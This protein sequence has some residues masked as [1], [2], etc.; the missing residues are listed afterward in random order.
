MR[1]PL[2]GIRV[3]DLTIWQQGTYAS[4]L[5]ADLGAD[6][7]KVEERAFGR[8][9]TPLHPRARLGL[10]AYFETHNRGKRSLAL[11]LKHPRGREALL[12]WRGGRRLPDELPRRG[13]RP[14]RPR[15]PGAGGSEPGA[16]LRPD[17]R[18]RSPRRRSRPR[19]VRHPCAGARWA[20]ERDRR[21]DDPPLPAGVPIADQ[22]GAL[23]ATIAVLAGLLGRA[24]ERERHAARYVV[25]GEPAVAA[26]VQHHALP[27]RRRSCRSDASAAG[28]TPF[29]RA[30]PGRRRASG[31]SSAC[32]S[33]ARGR[34]SRAAIGR[35][36]LISDERFDTYRKRAAEHAPGADRDPRRR[37]RA[38]SRPR[39]RC[40]G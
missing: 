40:G 7:I 17:V 9:R 26:V 38:A 5:L 30:V 16:S 21:T 36:E 33:T 23:H 19:L 29:W 10:S 8:S 27:L 35:A 20:D 24:R 34:K 11:D 22:V 37:V 39:S 28:A 15:V 18:A 2:Q 3:L 4:A 14:A 1:R 32:C 6:V 13:D 12:A 31:S 25:A